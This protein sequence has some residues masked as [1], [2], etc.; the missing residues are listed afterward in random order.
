MNLSMVAAV[1]LLAGS[2]PAAEPSSPPQ[3]EQTLR[4]G[5][6]GD[7]RVW[8][9]QAQPT[10]VVLFI[11]DENGWTEQT[12]ELA[13]AVAGPDALVA[14]VDLAAYEKAVSGGS[15][16]CVNPS[17]DF[18]ALSRA[19]QQQAALPSEQPAILAGHALGGELAYAVLAEAPP[20]TF[21]GAVSGAFCPL[22][23]FSR[24]LCPGA[25][26]TFLVNGQRH[27]LQPAKKLDAQWR[28]VQGTRDPYCKVAAIQRFTKPMPSATVIPVKDATHVLGKGMPEAAVMAQAV[29]AV[30]AATAVAQP[31][32]AADVGAGS[33]KNGAA[34]AVTGAST[35][36]GPADAGVIKAGV[37]K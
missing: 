19:V 9:P 13:K 17:S 8:K 11:S 29:D 7:V 12:T 24:P 30:V 4:F 10:R 27:F 2:P 34:D 3:G 31:G 15:A 26:L 5:D 35:A 14:G 20:K 23:S 33:A 1:V 22:F 36:G 32:A 6:F 18:A 16:A 21:R 28:V 37:K 25:G